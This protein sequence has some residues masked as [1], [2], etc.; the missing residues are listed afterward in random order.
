MEEKNNIL[1]LL[2]IALAL[3]IF[4]IFFEAAFQ[5]S[6]IS[7]LSGLSPWRTAVVIINGAAIMLLPLTLLMAVVGL[8]LAVFRSS[9]LVC[10]LIRSVVLLAFSLAFVTV[11]FI[12]IDMMVY[13]SFD[14][15]VFTLSAAKRWLIL[16]AVVLVAFF[17]FIMKGEPLFKA[18]A[19]HTRL[20]KAAYILLFVFFAVSV[21]ARLP[22][23]ALSVEGYSLAYGERKRLPDIILFTA[24]GIDADHVSLY[25][26]DRETT[27]NLDRLSEMSIVYKRAFSSSGNSRGSDT[28]I[29]T[30]KSPLAT[31]V[32][33][34]PDILMGE[35]SFEHLPGILAE[36]GYYCIDI[37]DGVYTSP[38]GINM[39]GFHNE[40]GLE[41][42]FSGLE[43]H[44]GRLKR[45]FNLEFYFLNEFGRRVIARSTYITGHSIKLPYYKS[46]I[47]GADI[48]GVGDLERVQYA[49]EKIKEVG[50]PIFLHVHLMKTHGAR[51]LDI[52]KKFSAGREQKEKWETDFYDDA[53]L[54]SDFLFDMVLKA[55]VES[56]KF[57]DSLIVFQ[58]DH[59]MMWSSDHVL[60]LVV[61]LPGQ[62]S[63]RV[64]DEPVQYM[65]IAP[66]I[67]RYLDA[68]IPDWMEGAVIFP[69]LDH[70]ALRGRPIYSF[71]VHKTLLDVE[72]RER[73]KESVGPPFFGMDNANI[74]RDGL[75]YKLNL[76]SG[77]GV[78]E[79]VY[80]DPSGLN[81]RKET[82]E[83]EYREELL[84][85][86]EGK[87]IDVSTLR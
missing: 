55:L 4:I 27:P 80:A 18:L 34:P 81:K 83:R 85:Y 45:L 64:V 12:H 6:K 26:Y 11:V 61:H 84:S 33:F 69:G 21:F 43:S 68:G 22:L 44:R 65:D 42:G 3:V 16:A 39:Y 8:L 7:F 82:L 52:V 36:M 70:E 37:G 87:G 56:G 9:P 51:F 57:D 28:S 74:L 5:L 25:G 14:V 79:T 19:G 59:G 20:I 54:T 47:L 73:H 1:P 30:G 31:R 63:G 13:S 75:I 24:D 78:L 10:R 40:N 32:L 66:S 38:G 86:M 67:L 58:T 48:W 49:A 46:M 17:L 76:E 35:D 60:P 72:K 71:N 23:G 2:G 77:R 41:T 50:A 15:N 53:I 29:L 62:K